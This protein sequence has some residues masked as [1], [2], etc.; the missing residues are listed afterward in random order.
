[1]NSTTAA[2]VLSL[3]EAASYRPQQVVELS[4]E[5]AAAKHQ[6]DWFKRQVFGQKSERRLIDSASGQMSLGEAI[7]QDQVAPPPVPSAK[8]L[9]TRGDRRPR[10][11]IPAM[12][13]CRSSMSRG[14][15]SK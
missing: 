14:C 8:S 5:L 11:P 3:D 13:A 2:R 10:S 1:M 12:T 9:R 6:L 15:R 7:T 4:R